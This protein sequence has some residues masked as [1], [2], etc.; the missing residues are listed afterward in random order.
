M[1]LRQM[2]Y[3]ILLAK[4]QSFSLSA[5]KMGVSQPSFS[6]QILA[7]EK[8]LGVDLFNR[9]TVPISLTPAGEHFVQEAKE[10]VYKE[11]QLLSTMERFRAGD[12]GR[13]TI[14][15]SQFRGIYMLKSVIKRLREKYPRIQVCLQET[16]TDILRQEAAEGKYDFAIVNLPVDESVLDVIPMEKDKLVVAVPNGYLDKLGCKAEKPLA[17]VSLSDCKD[18]PFVIVKSGQEM[19]KYFDSLCAKAEIRPHVS[20]EVHYITTAWEMACAGIGATVLPLQYIENESVHKGV[21]LFTLK[22]SV[23]V[24]QPAVIKR[25]GKQLPEYAEYAISLLCEKTID[26]G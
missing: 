14:G 26:K 18:I 17:G 3:A 12:E 1:N 10:L 22:D 5:E 24:R 2:Q 13:L 6:K 4:T 23:F 9:D 8:E 7:L 15:I 16:S 11:E 25:R 19:R 21:T 20:M